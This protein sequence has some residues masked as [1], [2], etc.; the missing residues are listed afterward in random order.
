MRWVAYALG[1]KYMH[2]VTYELGNIRA[3]MCCENE[4]NSN[5]CIKLI[6]SLII[7]TTIKKG[8]NTSQNFFSP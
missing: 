1:N 3:R 6:M 2:W 4:F 8:C 5:K 7:I